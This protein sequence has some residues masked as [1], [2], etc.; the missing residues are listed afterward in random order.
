M[1]TTEQ[2]TLCAHNGRVVNTMAI[3]V[4]DRPP[5]IVFWHQQLFVRTPG[6][7]GVHYR[8]AWCYPGLSG[9]SDTIGCD[10]PWAGEG[11]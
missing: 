7:N 1:K 8:E 10:P 4:F 2:I 9:E 6:E 3:P 11:R 5:A